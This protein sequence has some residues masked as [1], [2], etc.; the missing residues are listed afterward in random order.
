MKLA[1]SVQSAMVNTLKED[2]GRIEDLG[3]KYALFYVLV[4]AEMPSIL[5]EISFI[6]NHE[7]EKRLSGES[8]KDKLAEGIASGINSYIAQATPVISPVKLSEKD[9]DK[10]APSQRKRIKRERTLNKG[11]KRTGD[12]I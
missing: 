10:S 12:S 8:Y 2:Y 11:P 4:G 9:K 7:E 3:V 1:S 6:S 5:I